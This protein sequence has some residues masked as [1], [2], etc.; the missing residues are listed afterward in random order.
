M[1]RISAHHVEFDPAA[2]KEAVLPQVAAELDRRLKEATRHDRIEFDI[3]V[4]LGPEAR[5][6]K[7]AT[8]EK[9]GK[10]VG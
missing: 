7:E 3:K 1:P 6:R 8:E 2:I 4:V 10:S 5:T 9:H